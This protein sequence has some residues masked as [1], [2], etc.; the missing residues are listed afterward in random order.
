MSPSALGVAHTMDLQE[1]LHVL[2]LVTCVETKKEQ[3]LT[4]GLTDPHV[5]V[6]DL[7][8]ES[9]SPFRTP[10]VVDSAHEQVTLL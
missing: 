2:T 3:L 9:L 7:I 6:A 8:T 1:L 4:D 10:E 5:T